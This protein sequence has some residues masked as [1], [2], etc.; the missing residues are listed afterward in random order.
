[1]R[2]R[3]VKKTRQLLSD[4]NQEVRETLAPAA[5]QAVLLTTAA[6][7]TPQLRSGTVSL[8]VTSP[9]FLDVVGYATD[10]WLRC[11]FIGVDAASVALTVPNKL[12]DWQQAM[13][14]VFHELFRVVRP[15][16]HVVFEV[17]EVRGGA[18]RLEE[19][20]LPCGVAA[21]FDPVL[22]LINDQKFTKTANCWGVDNHFKGTN[23]N[24]VVVF[25]KRGPPAG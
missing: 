9:P 19:A 1:V 5:K 7:A 25:R 8:V 3:I 18:V 21:G 12:E 2:E 11:W 13:T 4:Y 15:G 16:G 10:N 17:G 23:T 14:A 6:G 24:R 20:V 22:V